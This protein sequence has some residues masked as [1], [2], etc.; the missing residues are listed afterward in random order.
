MPISR[1]E[2][3]G[4]RIDLTF[5]VVRILAATPD[6]GFSAEE[7]QQLL[8][9]KDKREAPLVEVERALEIPVQRDRVR[10]REIENQRWYNLMQRR[11]GFRTER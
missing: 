9:E 8:M 4:G 3:E 7:V 11:L 1:E 10:M 6:L 2:L 5:P